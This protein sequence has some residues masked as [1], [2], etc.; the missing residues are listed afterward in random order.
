MISYNAHKRER[1]GQTAWHAALRVHREGEGHNL[2]FLSL[3][4]KKGVFFEI[5][6]RNAICIKIYLEKARRRS[7]AVGA[8]VMREALAAVP[9]STA[10]RAADL[11]GFCGWLGDLKILRIIKTEKEHKASLERAAEEVFRRVSPP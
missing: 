6:L 4:V 5:I 10:E 7:I 8:V 11:A 9:S 3:I 1:A 2:Q